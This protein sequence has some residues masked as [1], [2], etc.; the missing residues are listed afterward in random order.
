VKGVIVER[1]WKPL[2]GGRPRSQVWRSRRPHL[3][4]K[5]R[6]HFLGNPAGIAADAPPDRVW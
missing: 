2:S 4:H 3:S 5:L 6:D 1:R